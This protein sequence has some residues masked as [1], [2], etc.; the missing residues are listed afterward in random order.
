MLSLALA[1]EG[2]GPDG[3]APFP[4]AMEGSLKLDQ[5]IASLLGITLRPYT[6]SIDAAL[7]LTDRRVYDYREGWVNGHVGGTSFAQV[8]VE[9]SY[10]DTPALSLCAASLRA[11][12]NAPRFVYAIGHRDDLGA[13]GMFFGPTE[14]LQSCLDYE[15]D[16]AECRRFCYVIEFDNSTRPPT[17]R[18]VARWKP[19]S[20]AWLLRK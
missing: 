8:G 11:L 3:E 13:Y 14:S 4:F 18:V 19:V 6:T 16:E 15:P 5:E 9:E 20:R 2:R 1:L 10:A 12:A 7:S 17:N